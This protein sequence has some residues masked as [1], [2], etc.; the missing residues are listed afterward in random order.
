[1]GEQDV[2]PHA[3]RDG[4]GDA[5]IEGEIKRS[6]HRDGGEAHEHRGRQRFE[7]SGQDAF[8][9]HEPQPFSQ[10][11]EQHRGV[12]HRGDGRGQ[13][14]PTHP[15][16]PHEGQV[17]D[18]VDEQAERGH[19]DGGLGVLQ[20]IESVD[21][22]LDSGKGR[23]AQAICR[24]RR[25]GQERL[26]GREA[27]V[28]KQDRDDGDPQSDQSHHGRQ[29]GEEHQP[30]GQVDVL[31]QFLEISLRHV[32]RE[33]RHDRRGDGDA[34]QGERELHQPVGVVERR[35]GPFDQEGGADGVE[36]RVDLVHRQSH[37]GGKDQPAH[38]E[39]ARMGGV[40]P[41]TRRHLFLPEQ[42]DQDEEMEESAHRRAEGQSLDGPAFADR[43]EQAEHQEQDE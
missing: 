42:R 19:A 43:R 23:K 29:D 1:V 4:Q 13:C 6:D 31:L 10:E 36:E 30:D 16:S 2:E 28:F 15:P 32:S 40:P 38:F 34:E 27:P 12:D 41:P 35:D 33:L 17:P 9:P 37:H 20:G 11:D 26:P 21:Q 25:V 24:H 5:E 14:Q 22:D 7:E 18:H 39:H 8:P 3:D